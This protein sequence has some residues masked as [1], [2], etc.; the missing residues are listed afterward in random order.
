ML[1]IRKW[2]IKEKT[3]LKKK[4]KWNKNWQKSF[5][6][7]APMPGQHPCLVFLTSL[8]PV[9]LDSGFSQHI[10]GRLWQVRTLGHR[11]P[12]SVIKRS[13]TGLWL[14]PHHAFGCLLPPSVAREMESMSNSGTSGPRDFWPGS[15][16]VPSDG[17]LWRE[18]WSALS[19]PQHI[20]YL[21]LFS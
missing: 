2:R 12:A 13:H 20:L 11:C 6:S 17:L 21:A 16:Q 19:M 14:W 5:G 10:G 8:K 1:E 15:R 4:M 18:E 3:A 9:R 7:W